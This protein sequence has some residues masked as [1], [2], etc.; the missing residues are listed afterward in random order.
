MEARHGG[1]DS[2]AS[3][4]ATESSDGIAGVAQVQTR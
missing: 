3:R 4:G 2:L 1:G